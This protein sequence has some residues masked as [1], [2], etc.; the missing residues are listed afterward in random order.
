[1]ETGPWPVEPPAAWHRGA[2]DGAD[3]DRDVVDLDELRRKRAG[4][5]TPL[6]GIRLRVKPRRISD[7]VGDL[8]DSPP[9]AGPGGR[10]RK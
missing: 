10:H 9:A 6:A 3:R 2:I 1:M 8:D 5:A 7:D 4:D